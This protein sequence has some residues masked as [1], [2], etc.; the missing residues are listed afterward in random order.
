MPAYISF[1]ASY[2]G[3]WGR[4]HYRKDIISYI[5]NLTVETP[6][7]VSVIQDFFSKHGGEHDYPTSVQALI[8]DWSRRVW[9]EFSENQLSGTTTDVPYDSSPR[10][11]FFV[12]GPDASG[13]NNGRW[14][15]IMLTQLVR[16][17]K[18]VY[19][20]N[21]VLQDM[22]YRKLLG[23]ESSLCERTS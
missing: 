16:G 12:P 20:S 13:A 2:Y 15:E 17:H 6:I 4:R 1:D 18:R 7:D 23:K 3:G 11:S 14:R 21:S 10:V 19:R 5:N 8:H 9:V 22:Q